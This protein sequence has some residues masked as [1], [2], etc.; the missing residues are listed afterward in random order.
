MIK[1]AAKVAL[2]LAVSGL[3]VV[4]PGTA[5]EPAAGPAVDPPTIPTLP[6]IP[7]VPGVK[8][9]RLKLSLDGTQRSVRKDLR[10][11]GAEGPCQLDVNSTTEELWKFGRKGG[12]V[13]EFQKIGKRLTLYRRV[14]REPG[15]TAFET[16]GTLVRTNTG[17]G[18]T[19]TGPPGCNGIFPT[20]QVTCNTSFPVLRDLRLDFDSSEHLPKLLLGPTHDANNKYSADKSPVKRCAASYVG[21]TMGGAV[22]TI[23]YPDFDDIPIYVSATTLLEKKEISGHREVQT[24]QPP[25]AGISDVTFS[26]LN[27]KLERVKTKKKR[28]RKH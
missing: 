2:G 27:F 5:S 4:S 19:L 24:T 22:P 15:D 11:I 8:K 7:N 13:L 9:L 16:K 21:Q 25:S 28:R 12:V 26:T 14:G 20:E 10:T 6:K 3:V 23:V 17:S 1:L 18:L